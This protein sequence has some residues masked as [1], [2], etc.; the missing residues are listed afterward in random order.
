MSDYKYEMQLL[1]E[2]KA[3][4]LHGKDFH[5]LPQA[6]QDKLYRGAMEDW[7]DQQYAKAERLEDR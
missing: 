3:E 6:E 7:T 2:Q 4:E 5:S 1:A